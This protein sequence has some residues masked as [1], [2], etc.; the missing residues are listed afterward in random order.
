MN[1]RSILILLC[2]AAVLAGAI[3]WLGRPT[4][5][6][7]PPSPLLDLDPLKVDRIELK[8]S[9]DATLAAE[10]TRSPQGTWIMHWRAGDS[11]GDWPAISSRLAGAFKLLAKITADPRA[12]LET[13]GDPAWITLHTPESVFKLRA[14]K[15]SFGGRGVIIRD[16][17]PITDKASLPPAAADVE[18]QLVQIFQRNDVLAWRDM[19]LFP[20]E[21]A[22]ASR[23]EITTPD[24]PTL[25]A[26]RI[27]ARWGLTA[28]VSAPADPAQAAGLLAALKKLRITRFADDA[29]LAWKQVPD[30]Q[31]KGLLII[32]TDHRTPDGDPKSRW[33]LRQELRLGPPA[34]A[35]DDQLLASAQV[36]ITRPDQPAQILWGPTPIIVDG[37]TARDVLRPAGSFISRLATTTV[38]ADVRRLTLTSDRGEFSARRSLDTWL[39]PDG[40]ELSLIQREAIRAIIEFLTTTT[41]DR[42]EFQPPAQPSPTP[43]TPTTPT[44]TRI[45]LSAPDGPP[46]DEVLAALLPTDDP[47]KQQL[48]ITSGPITRFYSGDAANTWSQSLELLLK[49]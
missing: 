15:R 30:D 7:T 20:L 12:S 47:A 41:A 33:T 46:L 28:P 34:G 4:A 25:R 21:L 27:S 29:A 49:H 5:P 43:T 38:A 37:P 8:W 19:T 14:A 9:A 40:A 3:L 10:V 2:V 36:S 26:A 35:A 6:A 44:P 13:A 11:S 42:V 23:F 1:A 32:E 39:A 48:A 31:L 24:A 22:D 17:P 16:P 45:T 18:G